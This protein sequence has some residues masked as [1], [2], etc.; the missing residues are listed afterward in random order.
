[1]DPDFKI[2]VPISKETAKNILEPTLVPLSQ[3]VGGIIQW[4]FQ[5][6]IE[7][8]IVRE[9]DLAKLRDSLQPKM[10]EIP[11]ANRTSDNLG[12]TLKAVEDSKYQLT[13]DIMVE[14]FANLISQTLDDRKHVKPIFS[15]ILQEMAPE[16]ALLFKNIFEKKIMFITKGSA[17]SP[18]VNDDRFR[19]FDET[20][21]F[22]VVNKPDFDLWRDTSSLAEM[23][24]DNVIES[25]SIDSFLFLLSKQ[26]IEVDENEKWNAMI[27]SVEK[28]AL[29]NSAVLQN[30]LDRYKD[31]IKKI[32]SKFKTSV[33][34]LSPLGKALA[35]SILNIV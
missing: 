8:G 16:D 2:D 6:P 13:S 3:A 17:N 12:L 18:F 10:K 15:A 30:W 22:L 1:M 33:Y 31:N 7:Y 11:E 25:Y 35:D 34:R 21:M 24:Y 9:N 28:K 14:Y 20:K 32:E 23:H 4:V 5:K 19:V 26:L 29:E 27:P